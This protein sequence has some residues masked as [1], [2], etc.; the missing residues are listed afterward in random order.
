MITVKI[1]ICFCDVKENFKGGHECLFLVCSMIHFG[2]SSGKCEKKYGLKQEFLKVE[3]H[4]EKIYEDTWED[5]K[6]EWEPCLKLNVL[7]SSFFTRYI[8]IS[9]KVTGF[10]MKNCFCLPSSG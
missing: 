8:T 3:M 4:H 9:A 6:D 5:L 10:G 7:S 1:F 2:G